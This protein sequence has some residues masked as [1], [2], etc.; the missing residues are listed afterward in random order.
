MPL[1][2]HFSRSLRADPAELAGIAATV[3]A[4]IA[5]VLLLFTYAPAREALRAIAPLMV[6]LIKPELP[7]PPK[8]EPKVEQ[9]P[10]PL[11][12]KRVQPQVVQ[13]QSIL[14]AQTTVPTTAQVSA[15]PEPKPAPP[16][17]AKPM[18]PAQVIP[19]SFNANYLDNPA[20]A[21]PTLSRRMGEQGRVMLRVFVEADGLPSKLEVRTSSGFERL[22]Q[23]ALDAV[24][25]WKFVPAKQGDQAVAAW[26]VVPIL[27]NLKG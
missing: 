15:Q 22:D 25:R 21:Y 20:P 4:H 23:S 9:L 8:P 10:K 16:V 11:P 17:D 19:P 26:V 13:E 1:L 14:A 6:E 27:F 2:S 18:P 3:L 7:A 5:V 12:V 24:R